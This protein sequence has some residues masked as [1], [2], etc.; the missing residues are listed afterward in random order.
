MDRARGW[1]FTILRNAFLQ[2]LQ[3][4]QPVSATSVGMDMDAVPAG[5]GSSPAIDAAELQA[6]LNE[7]PV[8]FRV[9]LAM[10]YFEDFS[11]REIAEKL[12]LPMGTV[13]S[14]LARA[15]GHLRTKLLETEPARLG[16][17]WPAD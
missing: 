3:R 10:Y 4:T 8:E 1:L 13:M 5:N 6:A 9:V 15:K 14:R 17:V 7:L 12:A 16:I 11:Y 2:T